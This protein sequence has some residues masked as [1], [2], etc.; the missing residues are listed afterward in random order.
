MTPFIFLGSIVAILGGTIAILYLSKKYD[1]PTQDTMPPQSVPIPP[2]TPIPAPTTPVTHETPTLVIDRAANL[3]AFA[4]AQK[5]FEG[6]FPGSTSYTHNN[7]GNC[8]DLHGEFIHFPTY[9]QGFQYLKNYILRVRNGQHKA[10][11]K[12]GDTSISQYTHIYTSDPEPSPTN[13]ANAIARAV[14]VFPS[15]MLKDIV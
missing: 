5:D 2:I 6:W 9:Y 13:Y 3:N 1:I 12:G 8:K 15:A 7:P 4:L 11:P 10:Y 14:K